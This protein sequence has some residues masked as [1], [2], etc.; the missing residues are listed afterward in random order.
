MRAGEDVVLEPR[1]VVISDLTVDTIE[2]GVDI[3]GTSYLDAAVKVTCSSGTY[4]RAIA[5]DLGAQLGTGGH[6]TALRRTRVGVFGSSDCVALESLPVAPLSPGAAA[7]RAMPSRMV[8]A[9]QVDRIRHGVQIPVPWTRSQ[10][11]TVAA[12]DEAGDLVAIADDTGELLR[13]RAVLVPA[14][15]DAG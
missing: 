5:R 11:G 4:I 10:T 13:Y 12:L 2:A 15:P 3:M 1:R 7:A 6:I 9:A 14:T 8:D